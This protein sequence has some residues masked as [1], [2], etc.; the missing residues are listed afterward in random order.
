MITRHLFNEFSLLFRE[1]MKNILR[2]FAFLR[3]L[4]NADGIMIDLL[5][6][7]KVQSDFFLWCHYPHNGISIVC[8]NVG[9]L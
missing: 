5:L 2:V 8:Y 4:E 9:Y 3:T 7:L 1:G 6:Q